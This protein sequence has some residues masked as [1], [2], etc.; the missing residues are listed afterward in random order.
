MAEESNEKKLPTRILNDRKYVLSHISMDM[1]TMNAEEFYYHMKE[2][3]SNYES[4]PVYKGKN[5]TKL[6]SLQ[7][8]SGWGVYVNQQISEVKQK[9][10]K[11]MDFNK[12]IDI[13]K[14]AS[15]KWSKMNKES[16]EEY[17]KKAIS[18][19]ENYLKMWRE[20]YETTKYDK[21]TICEELKTPD[22]I[23]SMKRKELIHYMGC[24]GK[25]NEVSKNIK[26]NTMINYLVEYL[27]TKFD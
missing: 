4:L 19:N 22:N 16:I 3:I 11:N 12:L 24:V 25:Y 5:K 15:E 20:K 6:H 9:S 10:G 1:E 23:K 8:I 13:R 18:M 26:N 27:G 7:S 21:L 14:K 17:K 2:N